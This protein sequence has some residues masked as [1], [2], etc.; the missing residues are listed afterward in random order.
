MKNPL[1]VLL[2]VLFL[3]VLGIIHVLHTHTHTHK[4]DRAPVSFPESRALLFLTLFRSSSSQVGIHHGAGGPLTSDSFVNVNY[5][6]LSGA[7]AAQGELYLL[8]CPQ[9]ARKNP[10]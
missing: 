3:C 8:G 6:S 5:C 10:E 7:V 1:I 2:P 4:S 9:P